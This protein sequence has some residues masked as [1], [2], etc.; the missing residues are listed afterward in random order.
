M[1]SSTRSGALY[2]LRNVLAEDDEEEHVELARGASMAG[3]SFRRESR[4]YYPSLA[5]LRKVH[6]L[7]FSPQSS[8]VMT[9]KF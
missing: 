2:G 4:G 1:T 3:A 8:F 6:K 9:G 5:A 7:L